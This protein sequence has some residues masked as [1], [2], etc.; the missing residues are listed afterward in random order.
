ML[1]SWKLGS[2][3]GI[4]IYVHSTFLLLPLLVISGFFG[5]EATGAGATLFLL[6]LVILINAQLSPLGASP[7]LR[8]V[9]GA[10]NASALKTGSRMWQPMSPNVAV[11]KSM[12][13]R[14]FTG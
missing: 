3:F 12:R 5:A 6:A 1:R 4:G 10:V 13:L 9:I 14:Q 11:P 8:T 7:S 2:L